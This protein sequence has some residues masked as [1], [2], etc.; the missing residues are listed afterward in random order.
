VHLRQR[1]Q[2]S[3]I[4][5]NHTKSTKARRENVSQKDG[6]WSD[7]IYWETFQLNRAKTAVQTRNSIEI[8][9]ASSSSLSSRARRSRKA[10]LLRLNHRE[11]KNQRRRQKLFCSFCNHK[12]NTKIFK[13][14]SNLNSKDYYQIL[15]VP[16]GA[17]DAALKKAYKKLAVKVR[18]EKL[19]ISRS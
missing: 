11:T 1:H 9:P 15:G 2:Q 13:M 8:S 10:S 6:R 7:V 5:Y 17:S 3:T 19:Q 18:S 16:R 4:L 14:T 12:N